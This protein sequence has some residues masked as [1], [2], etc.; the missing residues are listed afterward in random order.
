MRSISTLCKMS[1][2]HIRGKIVY[3]CVGRN[4]LNDENGVHHGS[5]IIGAA[6][7]F[8]VHPYIWACYREPI[9]QEE[10]VA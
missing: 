5:K 8:L 2:P 4:F 1:H 10:G 3:H 7:L 6:I 9:I